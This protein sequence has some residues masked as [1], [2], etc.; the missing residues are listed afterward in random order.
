MNNSRS[1]GTALMAYTRFSL[2]IVAD[3]V[4]KVASLQ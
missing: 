4:E 2:D 1:K 3:S